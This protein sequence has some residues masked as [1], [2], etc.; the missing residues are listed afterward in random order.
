M[1]SNTKKLSE[2]VGK[3]FSEHLWTAAV[4]LFIS[5]F[6]YLSIYLFIAWHYVILFRLKIIFHEILCVLKPFLQLKLAM[7]H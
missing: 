1:G 5:L 4:Y 3:S 2:I 6:I 7:L